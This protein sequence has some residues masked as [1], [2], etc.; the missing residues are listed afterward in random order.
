MSKSKIT[1][2]NDENR[3]LFVDSGGNDIYSIRKADLPEIRDKA[4]SDWIM[5]LLSKKWATVDLLYD[6][7]VQIQKEYPENSI[8]WY[9]TFFVV[10]K[11]NYLD[12]ATNLFLPREESLIDDVLNRIKFSRGE[13]NEET[14]LI[15]D[16]I[17][18]V[19]LAEYRLI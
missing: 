12:Y 19:K 8:D 11:K 9:A 17:V 16:E 14:N 4:Y 2:A 15:I 5:Q 7:A 18:Q 10:E 13:A 3:I 1:L 6:L